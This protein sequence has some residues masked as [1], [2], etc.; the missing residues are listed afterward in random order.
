MHL[1]KKTIEE[2]ERKFRLNLINSITGAKPSNLIGTT[3]SEGRNNL[4]I[5][6]SVV[7]LGSNPALLGFILRPTEEVPRHTYENIKETGFYTINSVHQEII[8]NAHYTSAK[9]SSEIDEF[10]RCGIEP[11]KLF[12]FIAPFVKSSVI[13][14]GMEFQEEVPLS[15]GTRLIIGSVEHIVIKDEMVEDNGYVNLDDPG[16]TAISGLNTYYKLDKLDSFSY[17]RAE[18]TPFFEGK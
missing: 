7:H 4:A 6:N 11:E 17:A 13:K 14:I 3:S 18:E 5:F 10:E 2:S 15:N 1:T 16:V 8:E 9:F 12:G